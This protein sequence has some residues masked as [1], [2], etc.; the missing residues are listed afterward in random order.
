MGQSVRARDRKSR[1]KSST[2]FRCY[3]EIDEIIPNASSSGEVLWRVKI[4]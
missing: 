1:M 3:T 4:S 2:D